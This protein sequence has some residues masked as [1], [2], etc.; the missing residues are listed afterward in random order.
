MFGNARAKGFPLEGHG[1]FFYVEIPTLDLSVMLSIEQIERSCSSGPSSS[2]PGS[3]RNRSPTC[4]RSRRPSRSTAAES[5]ANIT[6]EGQKY[7]ATVR[8]ALVDAMLDNSKNL[9]LGP[10]EWLTIA[11]R[12]SESGLSI[13]EI[14]NLRTTILRV[15]GSDLADFLAGRLTQGRSPAESRSPRVLIYNP[16]MVARAAPRR[17]RSLRRP[18]RRQACAKPVDLK[19]SVQ[20]ADARRAGSTRASRKARTSSCRA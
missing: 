7:R 19:Q 11:A 2:N 13:N 16:H 17:T 8:L 10:E 5:L 6:A 18:C 15:K 1:V 20:V 4:A 3:I 12:N 9:E 14:L